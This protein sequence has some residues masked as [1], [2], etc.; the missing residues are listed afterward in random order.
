MR[1]K[2]LFLLFFLVSLL[3]RIEAAAPGIHVLFA[4]AWIEVHRCDN[5]SD[6][7]AFIAGT[8]FP[9]I[10]YLGTLDRDETHE[11]HVKLHSIR[12]ADSAFSAGV[13]LHCY[14][15]EKRE[16]FVKKRKAKRLLKKVP[17]KERTKFLK[18]LE[19]EICWEQV[20]KEAASL[21][22]Q[23]RYSEESVAGDAAVCQWHQEMTLY[24]EQRPSELLKRLAEENRPFIQ[25]SPESVK[26]WAEL[27]PR[28][29]ED[30]RLIAYTREMLEFVSKDF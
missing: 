22:M 7:F 15:D 9:D 24:F 17:K 18:V 19:D 3:T 12:L 23:S 2:K 20:G 14:V 11:E 8:L 1:S 5:D 28:Y 10:R 30:P 27:L 6:K 13:L 16:A 21:A 4:Q 26:R 25:L 29:A